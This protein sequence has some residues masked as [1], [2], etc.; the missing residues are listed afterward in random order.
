MDFVDIKLNILLFLP[1]LLGV[2]IVGRSLSISNNYSDY[3]LS[4]DEKYTVMNL[5]NEI[6][7]CFS[8]IITNGS[9]E[10]KKIYF[11]KAEVDKLYD[12][13]GF[14]ELLRWSCIKR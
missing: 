4:Y 5:N 12:C 2:F 11:Y 1:F 3:C 9:L 6:G 14:L 8:Y 7:I 10:E 13:P